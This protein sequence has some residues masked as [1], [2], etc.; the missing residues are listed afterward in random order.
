MQMKMSP[1]PLFVGAKDKD[2]FCSIFFQRLCAVK[3]QTYV[4][5]SSI[6]RSFI[7]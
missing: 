5:S 7:N 3:G 1:E 6:I 4:S 2:T